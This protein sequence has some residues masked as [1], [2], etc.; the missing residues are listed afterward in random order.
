M[1]WENWIENLWRDLRFAVRSLS[2][3]WRLA[4]T[5][6]LTL[7]LGIGASTI[8]FSLVYHL[9]INPFPFKDASR[10]R[11][12]C[13]HDV[14]RNYGACGDTFSIP[15][16]INYRQQNHVFD[17][18]VGS[19]T[20]RVIVKTG[21]GAHD[22]AGAYVTTNVFDFY[23]MP[24]LFGRGFTPE[25]AKPGAAPVFVVNYY[26]WKS[27]FNADPHIVGKTIL[28]NGQPRTLVGVT[29]QLFQVY[30]ANILLPLGLSPGSEGTVRPGNNP[31][32]LQAIG[33]LKPGV[34]D[35]KAAADLE[36][37]SAQLTKAYPQDYPKRFTVTVLGVVESFM[38]SLRIMFYLL[39][40][41]VGILL[42]IA[43]SN[44]ANLLLGRAIARER[45][46]AIRTAVGA[47]RLALIRQ[48]LLESFVLATS[49]CSVGCLLAYLGLK[50]LLLVIPT[51]QLPDTSAV[52]L[53]AMVLS[54]AVGV[55]A[56]TIFICGFLP[57]LHS[58]GGHLWT[59]LTTSGK[60][61]NAG[62]QHGTLR[63]ILVV[64]EVSLSIVLLVGAA[65]MT[66]T[67]FA[68]THVSMG[69]DVDKVLFAELITPPGRYETNPKKKI[70]LR[71]IVDRVNMLPGVIAAGTTLSIPPLWWASGEVTVPG[72]TS[73]ERWTANFDLCSEDLFRTFGLKLLRG[74]LFSK[75]EVDSVRLVAV[76]NQSLAER[77]FAYQDPIGRKIKINDFD[78][79]PDIPHDTY[80][81]VIGVVSD[82]R[83]EGLQNPVKPEVFVP[84][85]IT[86]LG[87]RPILA[88]TTADP[89]LFLTDVRRA[90]WAVDSDVAISRTGSIEN[91]LDKGAYVEPKFDAIA[92][93]AFAGFGALLALLGIFSVMA[94]NV[95]LQTH[96]I[97][98]RLALGAGRGDILRM[99]LRKGLVLIAAGIVIGVAVSLGLTR[100]IASQLWGVS[101]TDP[102]TFAAVVICILVVGLAA[103][104]FP[105]RRATQVDPVITLRYE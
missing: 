103:C 31:V 84:Y 77:Y 50:A 90:I 26:L 36:V 8:M 62:A 27:D 85:T 46:I 53:D 5:A 17:D 34:S 55:A 30:G 2:K 75:N 67:L 71:Q 87:G 4:L 23:G 66:R 32:Y 76:I 69:F 54:F 47:S 1:H 42:L 43:C 74:R 82:V 44:V 28:V 56:L 21:G 64:V 89:N 63:S 88:R 33:L 40:A 51:G 20:L 80:F 94:Y 9:V 35:S 57:A 92:S 10:E 93:G 98:I 83:N 19:Y 41:A 16:F 52:G 72:K 14:T 102:W 105:A 58:L 22:F 73:S 78:H 86:G 97:G 60:G 7:A 37:I 12:I 3:D 96:D 13:I 59:R 79:V 25:D 38:G 70:F 11:V 45:E 48:F 15:E 101:A 6:V 18:M 91:F 68:L 65:L 39:F 100:F 99:V 81:E 49:A 104:F 95:A 29:P 24:L 61:V